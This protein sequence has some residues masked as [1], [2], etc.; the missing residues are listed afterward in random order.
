MGLGLV[1]MENKKKEQK[2]LDPKKKVKLTREDFFKTL[3]KA[4]APISE[5]SEKE[6]K[7]TSE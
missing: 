4:S 5:T 3:T 1:E 7:R 6:K 2:K